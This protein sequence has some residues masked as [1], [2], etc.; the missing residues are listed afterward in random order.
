[1][2]NRRRLSGEEPVLG[3]PPSREDS[4]LGHMPSMNPAAE[5]PFEDAI[6]AVSGERDQQSLV[7]ESRGAEPP[8]E[9]DDQ[10][11]GGGS[12][13]SNEARRGSGESSDPHRGGSSEE[14]QSLGSHSKHNK[15]GGSS[16]SKDELREHAEQ[17]LE[18]MQTGAAPIPTKVGRP[19]HKM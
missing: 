3:D 10:G 15:S 7:C 13:G 8:V 4:L 6:S 2:T 16:L 12:A 19:T 5:K 1:M 17:I 18:R 11:R 14:P 9:H